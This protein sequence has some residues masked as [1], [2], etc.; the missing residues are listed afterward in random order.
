MSC[1]R[2]PRFTL[3]C[4]TGKMTRSTCTEP[5]DSSRGSRGK[6]KKTS[7]LSDVDRVL[8]AKNF[9]APNAGKDTL[10]IQITAI[11]VRSTFNAK[12]GG[13]W[14]GRTK[15]PAMCICMIPPENSSIISQCTP[16][17]HSV[18][19][20]R[21]PC[22]RAGAGLTTSLRNSWVSTPGTPF[23]QSGAPGCRSRL[24]VSGIYRGRTWWVS[25]EAGCPE[26]ERT[27][28]A[29]VVRGVRLRRRGG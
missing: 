10:E 5:E 3:P 16:V 2:Q 14:P 28:V 4:T 18:V 8:Q 25:P 17:R 13:S 19:S 26:G 24:G 21:D 15:S 1:R 22:R 6:T 20:R 7:V 11:R 9:F 12:I 27:G 23:L 29:T